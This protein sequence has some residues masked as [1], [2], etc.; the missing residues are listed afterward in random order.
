MQGLI[1]APPPARQLSLFEQ[2][3][4]HEASLYHAPSLPGFF[5]LNSRAAPG[6]KLTQ[7]SYQNADLSKVLDL[8]LNGAS[9]DGGDCYISQQSFTNKTRLAAHLMSLSGAYVDLD[10]YACVK[11]AA[12]DLAKQLCAIESPD[13][14]AAFVLEYCDK[15]NIELPSLIVHSGRGLYLK[16]LLKQTIPRA[17]LPRWNALEN[18]FVKKFAELGADPQAADAS[19][20][21]RVCGTINQKAPHAHRHV[22]VLWTRPG[23][24]GIHT[25]DFGPL[26]DSILPYTQEQAH[27]FKAKFEVWDTRRAAIDKSAAASVKRVI[28]SAQD[29]LSALSSSVLWWDR[30]SDIRRLIELR[31]G[32]AGIPQ[33]H[34]QRN[35]F[36]WV[37]ANALGHNV[38]HS[39]LYKEIVTVYREICPSYTETEIKSSASSILSRAKS[40][41]LYKFKTGTL[42]THFS[43]TPDEER[44]LVTFGGGGK[45]KKEVNA[46]AMAFE[47]MAWLSPEE[48]A[49]ETLRR[50]RESGKYA[51]RMKALSNEENRAIALSLRQSGMSIRGIA[52]EI[53]VSVG[54]VHKWCKTLSD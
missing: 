47:K 3:D 25:F 30:L 41:N 10:P 53:G 46:G 43:I 40:G 14:R 39:R 24:D 29:P 8:L 26:C 44:H 49:A 23:T 22:R 28:K 34:D 50:Q 38:P 9:Y 19:R 12:P 16:W 42:R 32:S 31:Y 35:L 33:N 17:A 2:P 51:G 7:R 6:E 52:D 5:T 37:V 4:T 48:Y 27:A 11:G 36:C 1:L 20:I 13:D 18:E 15:R 54:S 45:R 21:L